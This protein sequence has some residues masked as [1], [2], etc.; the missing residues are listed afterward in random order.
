[1][2]DERLETLEK[3]GILHC[4]VSGI[5]KHNSQ[6]YGFKLTFLDE[7]VARHQKETIVSYLESLGFIMTVRKG[8]FDGGK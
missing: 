3:D 6:G 8:Y 1:M 2:I 4:T 5:I 7:K